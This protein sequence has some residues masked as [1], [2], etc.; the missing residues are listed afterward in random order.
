M[1]DQLPPLKNDTGARGAAWANV[2]LFALQH[3]VQTLVCG[4]VAVILGYSAHS[5]R[6]AYISFDSACS[7]STSSTPNP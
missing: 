6:D 7:S 1:S 5:I 3:P 4:L 2:A